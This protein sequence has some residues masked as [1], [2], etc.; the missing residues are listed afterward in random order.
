[1][2]KIHLIKKT[3]GKSKWENKESKLSKRQLMGEYPV[4]AY[5]RKYTS[6]SLGNFCFIDRTNNELDLLIH[7]S[8]LILRDRPTLNFQSSSV[9]PCLF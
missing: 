1:M 4:N 6:A 7:E 5:I 8:L 9:P 3:S 2:D